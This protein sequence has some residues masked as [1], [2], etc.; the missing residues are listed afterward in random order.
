MRLLQ[1]SCYRLWSG[2]EKFRF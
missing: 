1:H 2:A